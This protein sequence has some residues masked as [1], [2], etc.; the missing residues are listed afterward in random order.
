MQIA[1]ICSPH[2]TGTRLALC[3]LFLIRPAHIA[4]EKWEERFAWPADGKPPYPP[5]THRV[6]RAV[7]TYLAVV[8]TIAALL[9][10]FTPFPALT[11]LGK[12]ARMLAG[13]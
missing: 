11:W 2:H 8:L 6:V 7:V 4:Q 13:G 10:A 5:L 12:T 9:Q 1:P 3:E